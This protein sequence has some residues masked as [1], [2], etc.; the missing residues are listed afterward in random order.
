MSKSDFNKAAKHVCSP[1]NLLHTFTTAF[2]VTTYEELLLS[3]QF[4]IAV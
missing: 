1:L 2:P 4:K 3:V